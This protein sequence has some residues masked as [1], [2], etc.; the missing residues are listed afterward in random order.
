MSASLGACLSTVKFIPDIMTPG[1]Q[2]GN[3]DNLIRL[4]VGCEDLND[5]LDD[6]NQALD[7]ISD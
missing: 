2:A 1:K 3:G 7:T 4:S 6:L 5:L